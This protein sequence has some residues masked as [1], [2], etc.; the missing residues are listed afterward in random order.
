MTNNIYVNYAN[1][2][3]NIDSDDNVDVPEG[4][5]FGVEYD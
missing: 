5:G 1:G 3:E 2:L 4:P